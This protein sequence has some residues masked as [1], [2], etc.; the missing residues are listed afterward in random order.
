LR[1]HGAYP[2]K[3]QIMKDATS[4]RV[5]KIDIPRPRPPAIGVDS[6]GN[7]PNPLPPNNQL[8]K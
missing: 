1:L 4:V 3:E 5:I 2:T 6:T 7:K 8:K